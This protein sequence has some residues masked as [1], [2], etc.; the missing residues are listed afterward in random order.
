MKKV[1]VI[2][3]GISG[4]TCA[5]DLQK[6]G[7]EV[8]VYEKE[9]YVGGRMSTRTKDD[10]PFDIGADHLGNSYKVMQEYC[11]E[12]NVP[13]VP[14][15]KPKYAILRDGELRHHYKV[16]NKWEQM[17]L[18][19]YA[20]FLRH[21]TDFFDLTTT[22]RFHLGNAFDHIQSIAGK[23]SAEY[24]A[25]GV[26]NGYQF[27]SAREVSK[28]TFIAYMQSIKHEDWLLHKTE[29]GM[30]AL[31]QAMADKLDVRLNTAVQ[32]V[33]KDEKYTVVT[34]DTTEEFDIV[35]M[36]TTANVTSKLLEK[37]SRPLRN[38]LE[39]TEYASTIS[40]A[41][42]I[43]AKKLPPETNV[44]TPWVE[45][46]KIASYTNQLM[47]GNEWRAGETSMLCAWL[48]EEYA[49]E[50]FDKSDEEIFEL[51]RQAL[52][53]VCPWLETVEDLQ[54]YDLYKWTHAMPKFSEK[55]IARVAIYLR[56][57]QGKDGMYL[58]GD[59]LNSPWTEGALR[60]GVRVAK[61]IIRLK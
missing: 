34:S 54:P 41:Y 6:A 29:G 3:A 43:E 47:K 61:S 45:S 18:A 52:A 11:K 16:V 32:S 1:A 57:E 17:R 58:C 40:L 51:S 31:S 39:S 15:V 42:K 50:I 35:V 8:T 36:A 25:N 24:L 33:K 44:F 19:F 48:H 2:G 20:F 12:L 53:E 30:I 55:H 27:H 56:E 10:L 46:K 23:Q 13:W 49:Q 7:F 38:V 4:L 9:A 37:Q 59:Y 5:Y 21:N 14:M 60:C 26:V 22:T 28:G